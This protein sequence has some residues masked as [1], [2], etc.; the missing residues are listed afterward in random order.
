MIKVKVK[1]KKKKTNDTSEQLENFDDEDLKNQELSQDE[2]EDIK[3]Q[4]EAMNA[5]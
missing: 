5:V 3:K 1:K 4:L 2:M